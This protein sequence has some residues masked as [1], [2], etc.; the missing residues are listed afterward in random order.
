VLIAFFAWEA[1]RFATDRYVNKPAGGAASADAEDQAASAASRLQ[2]MVP[3]MRMALAVVIATIALLMALTSLGV[4]I[5]PILAGA[6]I[7]GLA[8][9]FGSQTLVRDIVSGIFYLADDA[10]RV[11]EYIDCGKAKGTVE[12]FT[13]RSLRLRH[14][15]GQIH[16][17]PFGQL[18]Q[19]TNFSRDWSTVKFN[20]RFDRDV[21][22]ELLR[23]TTKKIGQ[24][25]AE[26]PKFKDDFLEPLKM[27]GVADIA[28]NAMIVR[29]KFT[30]RP[31]R[32]T[33]IQREAIKRL[34]PAFKAAK[35]GF[36]QATVS[37]QTLGGL[38]PVS[39]AASAAA[40]TGSAQIIP[41]DA[42]KS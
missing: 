38:S 14:Q 29:F 17:I 37:V 35:I 21:D 1:V 31:T 4:N 30:V 22:L 40:L 8:I 23:K 39:A 25:M 7:V 36:A 16:T 11:G 28:D 42:G 10:F 26:D 24:E 9:S 2:T 19:V 18:G 3:L 20:L 32:P 15:N 6:S 13:L 41:I 34:I 5:G 27:Q 33:L 12:G